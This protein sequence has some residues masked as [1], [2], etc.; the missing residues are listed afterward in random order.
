MTI[1]EARQQLIYRLMEHYEVE[2][3][4]NIAAIVMENVTGWAKI[5]QVNNKHVSLSPTIIKQIEEIAERLEKNE[6][7][8]YILNEAWFFGMKLY[9]DNTVLIPRPETE[10]LTEWILRTIGKWPQKTDRNYKIMDVGTGSGCI[11]IALRKHLPGYF[12]TWACDIDDLALTVAR[13]NADDLEALVDFVP[14]NFLDSA[15]RQQLP[16]IDVLVSNPPYV[17]M[18]EKDQLHP[19]VIKHEPERALFVPD[20]DPLVFYAA[21]ADHAIE[22]VYHGGYLFVEIHEERA[23]D[24]VKL[25]E[26]KGLRDVEVKK[27]MQGKERMVRA[28]RNS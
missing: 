9:V 4:K 7:I 1:H 21:L 14:M 16:M 20:N 24:V 3:S 12:E 22:K 15:Q 10:E 23:K 2:E 19:N 18:N 27:D 5:D 13:R 26:Q 28:V 8:Q 11:P 6:P 25:F 17:A